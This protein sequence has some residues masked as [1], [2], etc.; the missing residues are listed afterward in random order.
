[1]LNH[2]VLTQEDIDIQIH[3]SDLPS[4]GP[5]FHSPEALLNA[6]DHYEKYNTLTAAG[7][8]PLNTYHAH[9][10]PP[11][12]EAYCMQR[13]LQKTLEEI[14][15]QHHELV[16]D[17][18]TMMEFEDVLEEI[19]DVDFEMDDTNADL[20]DAE[21]PQEPM[22]DDPD[23]FQDLSTQ[24]TYLLVIYMMTSWL[25]LQ[26]HLPCAACNA[27]LRILACLLFALSLTLVSPFVTLPS[28]MKVLGLDNLPIYELACCPLCHEVYPPAGSLHTVDE[29]VTC[30]VPLFL[31]DKTKCSFLCSKKTPSL[32]YPY[33]P[34]SHQ[35]QSI[36]SIPGIEDSLD[37]WHTKL[38]SPGVYTDIFDGDMCRNKLKAPDGT[39]FFANGPQDQR[40]PN[41]ELHIGVTL[42]IDCILPGPKEQ[43]PD[44][45]QCFLRPIISDQLCLWQ[46]GIRAPTPSCPNG[47]LVRVILVAVICDKP[48]AH[49]IGGFGS[50]SHTNLCHACWIMQADKD[51]AKAFLQNA[52]K[53]Q[54]DAEQCELSEWYCLLTTAAAHK[55]FIKDFT[56]RFT[57]LSR[58]PY[59]NLV[60]QINIW[61]QGKI[62]RANHKLC[63]L[64]ELLADFE[65]PVHCSKLPTDIGTP[66][67][68]SLTANQW[69]LLATLY[70]PIVIPQLWN[71]CLSDAAKEGPL[72]DRVALIAQ[73]E[74]E[75]TKNEEKQRENLQA[76]KDAKCLL[77]PQD[78]LNFLK[79][80]AALC[81]IIK[82]T[83]NDAKIDLADGL[84]W[85]YCT[86]VILLYGS[87]CMKPNHHYATHI[88]QYICNFGPLNGFWTFLFKCLNKIL[89]S[90]KTNNHSNRELETTFFNE[91]HR[92]CQSNRLVYTLL[93]A[94]EGSLSH[95]VS[96]IML[97]ASAEE[98]GTVASLASLSKE[99]GEA[100]GTAH[101]IPL[102]RNATFFDY[103]HASW[104]TGSRNWSLVHVVIPDKLGGP[105]I[106]AYGEIL[107][108]FRFDQDIHYAGESMFFIRMRW[109]RHWE[110][111]KEDI[112][113]TL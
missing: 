5:N 81:L 45:I 27:M 78:P 88:A 98:R 52:F 89:K 16:D 85:S 4:L 80:C 32:K 57:Q 84:I 51:K 47:H 62:L 93:R 34:L 8:H 14:Q 77:H 79:L 24:P 53:P 94:P 83:T 111:E 91:F 3:G 31:S 97:K 54:T 21:N 92:T 48:A 35:L 7:A 113:Y 23:P 44:E 29:C 49:K 56:T 60:N 87:H 69:L 10:L 2:G 43:S 11:D 103:Y 100:H 66:A 82:N 37:E 13:D 26:W 74:T 107:E 102:D 68:G 42:G 19:P 20:L 30:K 41:G 12:P 99:L 58:L 6:V 36:L 67:G 65:V 25:H 61:V 39:L 105:A 50:H 75:K 38:Q 106:N 104:T 55:N 72:T 15:R 22:E 95:Q 59:F 71:T 18:N 101:S 112:W 1:M 64:H 76:L 110:G 28:A 109:F 40:G 33:M 73:Q 70:G 96:D 86:E 9:H 90:Y 63:I 46:D 108:I 17:P